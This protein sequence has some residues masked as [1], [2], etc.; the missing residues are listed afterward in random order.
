MLSIYQE[1]KSPNQF[2]FTG[3]KIHF[4]SLGCPRNLVDSEVMLGILLKAGYEA[5]FA[6]QEADYIV[7]NT[8]GFLEAS[9]QESKETVQEALLHRKKEAKIIVTGCMVQTHHEELKNAFPKID[10]FLG[11]GD[12]QGI[13]GAV[14]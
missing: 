12:V 5:T 10:Y 2:L 6:L 8:C 14:Q 4:I 9:R 13:L 3:N 11:S 1:E 7:I